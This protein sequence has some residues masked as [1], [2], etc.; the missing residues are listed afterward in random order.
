[1][2]YLTPCLNYQASK[3]STLHRTFF[4]LLPP[5]RHNKP[6]L[7]TYWHI[8]YT[9]GSHFTE[10]ILKNHGSAKLYY[11]IN[12]SKVICKP[13]LVFATMFMPC[14]YKK[15][16]G[17]VYGALH[18]GKT[19]VCVKSDSQSIA[20]FRLIQFGISILLDQHRGSSR[21]G[22]LLVDYSSRYFALI[23]VIWVLVGYGITVG[24]SLCSRQMLIFSRNV[25]SLYNSKL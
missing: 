19:G 7:P 8:S 4:I 17:G 13:K 12:M 24:Q 3:D 5:I 20:I 25:H 1:M 14:V 10:Y 21:E 11:L 9:S 23:I 15:N 6:V 22:S 18:V 16:H 2:V